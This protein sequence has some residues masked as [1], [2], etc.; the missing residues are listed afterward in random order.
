M[1]AL[2]PPART[3]RSGRRPLPKSWAVA[4]T[5]SGLGLLFLGIAAAVAPGSIDAMWQAVRDRLVFAHIPAPSYLVVLGGVLL[6][7]SWILG[8]GRGS[9]ARLFKGSR[10]ARADMV[11]GAIE[12]LGW[13]PLVL[14]FVSAG[15]IWV[16]KHTA[17]GVMDLHLLERIGPAW[18]RFMVVVVIADFLGYWKHRFLHQLDFLWEAHKYHHAATEFT[19]L[20]G[21]RNHAVEY[22][23]SHLFSDLPLAVLGV[24]IHQYLGAGLVI[25]FV[26]LLQHSDLRWDYGWVGRWLVYGPVG[27]RI[28]HSPRVDQHTSNYG[29]LFVVWDRMFGTWYDG[30]DVNETIGLPRSE[31]P[32]N[33]RNLL[34]E[35]LHT[36]ARV[37]RAFGVSARTGRWAT[38][39]V[40]RPPDTTA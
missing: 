6:A 11:I 12:T 23:F 5:L 27:H 7:E 15:W 37:V 30:A 13:A 25:Y 19:I 16:I 2:V 39:P 18:F 28:H 21:S 14:A 20:T 22:A 26:E 38:G 1:I 10:S 9:L 36:V 35:Y 33:R 34:V 4:L 24:S 29:N 8:W 32:Y 3:T 17:D 31:N 40:M